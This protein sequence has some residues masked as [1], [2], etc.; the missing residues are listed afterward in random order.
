MRKLLSQIGDLFTWVYTLA[1]ML[2]DKLDKKI[3]DFFSG[4]IDFMIIPETFIAL[5]LIGIFFTIYLIVKL[6]GALF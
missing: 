6:I 3:G 4:W 1:E 2:S 5:L